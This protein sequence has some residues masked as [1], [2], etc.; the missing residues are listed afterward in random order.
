M[1]M[2]AKSS[3]AENAAVSRMRPHIGHDS[4]ADLSPTLEAY[5]HEIMQ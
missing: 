3:M 1:K 5:E 2:G 4:E